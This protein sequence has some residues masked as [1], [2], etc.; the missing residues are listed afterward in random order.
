M[1]I[2]VVRRKA[3]V[4]MSLFATSPLLFAKEHADPV[5]RSVAAQ[6]FDDVMST[7]S[8]SGPATLQKFFEPIYYLVEPFTWT[9]NADNGSDYSAV[10][11]P[12]GFVT[13]LASI[14]DPL[15]PWLRADGPYAQAAIVHDYLYW[16]QPAK[17]RE[18]ADNV[19]R[20]AMR[21]L[22]VAPATVALMYHAVR[23]L[24]NAAWVD[25]RRRSEQGEKRVLRRL[26]T[27]VPTRWRDWK[28][29]PD[30]F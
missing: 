12:K 11:V 17:G 3:A 2:N 20:I 23:T 7:K 13:D 8:L 26:P 9:P 29:Q 18:Y 28:G 14:P 10:V 4:A 6:W 27:T 1:S 15:F 24:G 19:F 16:T 25:N 30:V 21:D 22:E 5:A